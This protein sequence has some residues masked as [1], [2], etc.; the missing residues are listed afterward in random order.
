MVQNPKMELIILI[1]I[2]KNKVN[3]NNLKENHL[4]F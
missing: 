2:I 4:I 3:S 1:I